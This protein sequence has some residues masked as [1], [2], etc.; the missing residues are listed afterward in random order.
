MLPRQLW[1]VR[2]TGAFMNS[3]SWLWVDRWT[4]LML[5][6]CHGCNII[7]E[8][9][10][11]MKTISSIFVKRLIIVLIRP[12]IIALCC[13]P[14][15]CGFKACLYLCLSDLFPWGV[16]PRPYV[17]VLA[18]GSHPGQI[19]L[20]WCFIRHFTSLTL[21]VHLVYSV[22]RS[23]PKIAMFNPFL[24]RVGLRLIIIIIMYI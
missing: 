14:V 10:S 8:N 16:V 7:V 1:Q 24:D 2:I 20:K 18:T 11:T 12:A 15:G 6:L 17:P 23:H 5:R 3:E 21:D 9:I 4:Y 22:H 19:M 13:K